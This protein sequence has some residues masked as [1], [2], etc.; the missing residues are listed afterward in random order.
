MPPPLFDIDVFADSDWQ[1]TLGER[2]ALEGVLSQLKPK[3]TVELGTAQGGSLERIAAHSEEVHTFDLVDPPLERSSFPHVEFHVGDSHALLP[4]FLAE[5]AAAGRNVDFVLVDGDHSAE[6]ARQ[7]VVDLLGS[8]AVGKT[9]MLMHDTANE[10]VRGGL[11]RVHFDAY[12]KVA[13]VEL[14]FVC[15]RMFREPSLRYELWGGLGLAVVDASRQAY[16]AGS[17]MQTRYY[18][19]GLLL[20]ELRDAIAERERETASEGGNVPRSRE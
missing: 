20:P 1:M 6:G 10:A 3:L 8:P 13:Y 2:C 5:L 9:V 14:D 18:E 11:E 15:G 4:G 17:A 12:P 16:F 7:D 19:L